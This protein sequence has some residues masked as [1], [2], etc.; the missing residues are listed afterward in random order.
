MSKSKE[1]QATGVCRHCGQN[2]LI[3][4][5]DDWDPEDKTQEEYDQLATEQCECDQAQNELQKNKQKMNAI[6]RMAEFYDNLIS[7]I[8]T[9]TPEAIKEIQMLERQ[10]ALMISIIETVTDDVIGSAVIQIRPCE[11]FSVS[12]K[13]KG[14]LQIKRTFK[15]LEEWIF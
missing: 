1:N 8:T 12:Y 11:A 15:G 7:V 4:L 3:H 6:A 10:Q 13:A 5:P 2:M 14:D 9:N